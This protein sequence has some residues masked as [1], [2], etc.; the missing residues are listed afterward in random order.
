MSASPAPAHAPLASYRVQLRSEFGFDDVRRLAPYLRRLGIGDVYFSPLFRAREQSSHGYDVVNHSVIEPAFGGEEALERL[1]GELRSLNMGALLDVVP[2]HMGID[3]QN[4]AWWQDVLENGEGARFARHFDIDWDPPTEKLKRQVLLPYLGESYGKVLEQQQLKLLYAE[5]R[6][7]IEY[8]ERRFPVAPP[9][10]IIILRVMLEKLPP[11]V[12]AEDPNRME[13]ESI[14]AALENLPPRERREPEHLHH[15]YREQDISARRL[16]ELLQRSPMVSEALAAAL[17]QMNGQPGEP[18]SFDLL[19]ELLDAQP[20]RLSYWRTAV[21]EINYRRFFDINELAAIRVEEP[22]VFEAVHETAFRL[23]CNG[24]VTGLRIDHPD[25]LYD[26]T[27][28]FE[29]LQREW[30]RCPL[31]DELDEAGQKKERG[32]LYVVAEKILVHDEELRPDWSVSGT[33]GYEFL[34]MLNGVFVRREGVEAL[35]N[36]Y[37]VFIDRDDAFSEIVYDSKAAVLNYS[38]SSELHMLAWRL[39]RIAQRSRWSRDFTLSSLVRALREVIACF[40]VY[41]TYIRPGDVTPNDEDIR[42]TMMAVRLAKIRNKEMSWAYFDFIASVLLLEEPAGAP[43]DELDERREFVLKFQ[44]VTGPVMAKGVEDTAFYRYYPLA[45]LNEVGGEPNSRGVLP[46]EFHRFATR[47]R[48]D[49]PYALSATSTHDAKRGEDLRARVNVLSEIP[50]LWVEA[51][52]RWRSLN[53][54]HRREAEGDPAPDAN[55]E[56][57]LYQTLVGVWPASPDAPAP[58]EEL[59]ARVREYMRKAMREAKVNTSWLNVSEPHEQAVL[60]FITDVLDPRKSREFLADL[61]SF[62]RRIA[63]A[64]FLNSLG[65]TLLKICAPGAPDFYQGSELWEFSLV[66]PDNRRPVDFDHRAKLLDELARHAKEDLAALAKELVKSWPDPRVKMFL[67]WRALG[68]RSR[69]PELFLQGDYTPLAA[70]GE[71]SDHVVGF[72]R[73]HEGRWLIALAPRL[74]RSLGEASLEAVLTGWSKTT[75]PLPE[76]APRSWRCVLTGRRFETLRGKP[77]ARL[78]LKEIFASFPVALLTS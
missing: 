22:E 57:L 42:R 1:A 7:F 76:D 43:K 15:R 55:E 71:W 21:D 18:E 53:K 35:Q 13:L 32:P 19:D 30:R 37:S 34:N 60:E 10:W 66:D 25:G 31:E 77:S 24:W 70:E 9:S 63:D 41:R 20:Y 51:L 75:L 52:E 14:A 5:Q 50:E 45:S 64:G 48:T 26:P 49:W 44:Q 2:N 8:Y 74:T 58:G 3:D 39:N 62:A 38:M 40:P 36:I 54:Q 23:V 47:R 59:T 17:A 28:Y 27:Q 11:D 72:A 16:H 46:E 68:L 69:H 6:F 33:T 73:R 65:Q 61:E 67:I 12:P 4:N 78:P 29:N 56:Y